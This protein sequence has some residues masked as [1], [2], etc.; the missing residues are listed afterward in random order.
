MKKVFEKIADMIK[1]IFGY[2]IMICLLVG[3]LTFFGY[4]IALCIGGDAAG[5]ICM[6]I[7]ALEKFRPDLLAWNRRSETE[8]GD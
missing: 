7:Y 1:I 2:G 6:V 8:K 5:V 4:L 3:G